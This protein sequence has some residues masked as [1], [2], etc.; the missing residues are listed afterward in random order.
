[1]VWQIVHSIP[2]RIRLRYRDLIRQPLV[3]QLFEQRLRQAP[4]IDS[5]KVSQLTGSALIRYDTAVYDLADMLRLADETLI[6]SQRLQQ[7][8]Y[9]HPERST[10]VV[11]TSLGLGA[12]ADF[13]LPAV[14]PASAA[15]LLLSNVGTFGSAVGELRG[16]RPGTNLLY[17][18]I[19][20]ATVANGS[21]F[22]AALMGWMMNFWD[23]RYHRQ[24]EVAQRRLLGQFQ[25]RP[26]QAWVCQT[27]GQTA[28]RFQ[29]CSQVLVDV[30]KLEPNQE[31][32]V[33]AGGWIP[34]DGVVVAG[35]AQVDE[36]LVAGTTGLSE[37]RDGDQVWAGAWVAAGEL[38]VQAVSVAGETRLAAL[39]RMI[40]QGSTA[41]PAPL[42]VR[43]Q[44]FA[45]RTVLPT[46]ATAGT[47]L[48][49]GDLSTALAILR[50]DYATGPGM[51]APLGVVQDLHTAVDQG[52]I[53]RDSE[54]F[55]RIRH[56]QLVLIDV[57]RGSLHEW[58]RSAFTEA[59]ADGAGESWWHAARRQTRHEAELGLISE[60]STAGLSDL[61]RQLDADFIHGGMS[62]Q[63]KVRFLE[64]LRQRGISVGYVGSG[65]GAAELARLAD[66]AVA[67]GDLDAVRSDA[68]HAVV[69]QNSLEPLRELW[70]IAHHKL[71]REQTQKGF[72]VIPNLCCVAGAFMLDFTGMSSVLIS[73]LG[74]W[75]VYRHGTSWLRKKRPAAGA[76][77]PAR[78]N[79]PPHL[80]RT[81]L[82]TSI[83]TNGHRRARRHMNRSTNADS[84]HHVHHQAST[85]ADPA[86]QPEPE[87]GGGN[88]VGAA[89]GSHPTIEKIK[90][91]PTPVGV[92][93][94]GAGVAGLILPGPVGTPLIIAGGLV[95][96][97]RTFDRVASYFGDRFPHLHRTGLDAV[98][99]FLTDMDRRFPPETP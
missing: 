62:H 93:L 88:G 49:V 45:R 59:A 76:N 73:N 28:A 60:T 14:A 99:R 39:E 12:V 78:L 71:W 4:G 1:M 35:E 30:D 52:I 51:S 48:M 32:W 20:V 21:F 87:N 84:G 27:T 24:L 64:E 11:N 41:S 53:A 43:G 29:T 5:V 98:E 36:R 68:F 46:L 66:V 8:G 10:A 42:K 16:R 18:V 61:A 2:G 75:S 33:P 94:I 70:M 83:S 97:P 82:E 95:L 74:V 6:E 19:V 72:T 13:A 86:P 58:D 9:V 65:P 44:T 89:P 57:P 15:L 38:I 56:V 85:A 91:L 23:R 63:Q 69:L 3:V 77:S 34:V 55:H 96:A 17:S 7:R 22:A 79:H 90:R 92:L 54:L 40:E 50:P 47:G 80:R 81:E 26:R 25:R 67:V 31:I 37:K